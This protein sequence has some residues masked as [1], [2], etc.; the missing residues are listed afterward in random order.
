MGFYLRG[1]PPPWRKPPFLDPLF[2]GHFS[3]LFE[4][5]ILHPPGDPPRTPPSGGVPPPTP[6]GG[7]FGP[8]PDPP[9]EGGVFLDPPAGGGGLA[10]YP[11]RTPPWTGRSSAAPHA[12][13]S[14]VRRVGPAWPCASESAR[15]TMAQIDDR[16]QPASGR[17]G[18]LEISALP[19]VE[20]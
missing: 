15:K 13:Q 6:R 19:M 5:P 16:P 10:G 7:H 3:G 9:R 20:G 4:N 2:G 1:V 11:R 14:G 17:E 12:R 8:P 18:P